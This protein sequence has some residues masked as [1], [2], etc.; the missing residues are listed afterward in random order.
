[1][2]DNSISKYISVQRT[3]LGIM[4]FQNMEAYE[5]FRFI[6]VQTREAKVIKRMFRPMPSLFNLVQVKKIDH[7]F[8]NLLK[9]S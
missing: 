9:T 2:V 3:T 6:I 7:F 1:M 4:V 5:S 8:E